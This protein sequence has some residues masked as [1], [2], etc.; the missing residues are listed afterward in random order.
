M[1]ILVAADDK[2]FLRVTEDILARAGYE[3]I[4]ARDGTEALVTAMA[5]EPDIIVLDIILPGL[6]GTEVSRKLRKYSRTVSIPVLLVSTGVAELEVAAGNPRE[7]LADDFLHKPFK[8]DVFLDRIQRLEGR[9][10][11]LRTRATGKHPGPAPTNERRRQSRWPIDVEITARS[12]DSL[13]HHPMINIST[14]GVY[15]ELDRHLLRGEKIQLLFAIPDGVGMISAEG[16][17]AWCLE[18]EQGIHWGAGIRFT[19]VKPE[20]LDKI[21]RYTEAL[22]RVVLPCGETDANGDGDD[23]EQEGE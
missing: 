4:L 1:R 21:K 7:F 6:L 14:G 17:V 10:S 13:L 20:N 16:E 11:S 22:A 5:E 3:V 23:R 15:I 2:F 9:R 12:A 8:P 18:L 19:S